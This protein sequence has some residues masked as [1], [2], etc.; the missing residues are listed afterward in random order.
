[1]KLFFPTRTAARA[2][3]PANGKFVDLG[4]DAAKRWAVQLQK[5]VK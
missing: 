2:F 1:M 3:K 5:E 4:K